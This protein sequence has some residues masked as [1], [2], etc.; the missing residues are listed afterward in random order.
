LGTKSKKGRVMGVCISHHR[1]APKR[2]VDEG[3]ARENWGLEGDSHAGAER[4]ISLLA[5]EDIEAICKAHQI[6]APPGSFAENITT[7][8]IDLGQIKV[9]EWIRAGKATLQV[10]ARGK[11]PSEPHTYAYCGISLLPQKGIFARVIV[12]G[13]VR[14]GDLVETVASLEEKQRVRIEERRNSCE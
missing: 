2:N 1:Q 12:G 14:V 4:Q 8:G 11:D 5:S 6:L 7:R 9:G 3:M 10:V 13:S